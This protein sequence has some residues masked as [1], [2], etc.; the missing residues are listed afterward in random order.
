MDLED[1]TPQPYLK[2]LVP[3]TLT[4]LFNTICFTFSKER[5]FY[6][7]LLKILGFLPRHISLYRTAFVH[8]SV[9][10]TG[11]KGE[12]INNERLE[13]LGD[14]IL[15]AIVA[16]Y[17]FLQFPEGDEGLLT[18]LRSGIVKRKHLNAISV[19]IGIPELM[20]GNL[21][22]ANYV[23]HL[24]GNTLE[25]LIGAIYLDR[26]YNSARKFFTRKILNRYVDLIKLV[27]KDPDYK[28][29]VIE[30]AQK[31]R[32]EIIFETREVTDKVETAPL[33]VSVVKLNG[34]Y[35]GTGRA[36]TKKEA[37]QKA[38]KDALIHLK[39]S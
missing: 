27:N 37:E 8:K 36:D 6:F 30:R 7:R 22:P 4:G 2:N 34:Q 20:K 38:A 33:F 12:K 19:K 10:L 24:Y 5:H 13:Y 3:E 9:S 31:K 14:A 21:N 1:I 29:R 16:E 23:K 28:S 18:K 17:L 35:F 32:E 11:K 15:G 39:D 26:G 25:A